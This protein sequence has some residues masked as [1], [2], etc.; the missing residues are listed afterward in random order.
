LADCGHADTWRQ[1]VPVRDFAAHLPWLERVYRGEAGV[2][3]AAPVKLLIPTS[4][5]VG[6]Q[7]L[8]P[9]TAPLGAAIERAVGAW[10]ANLAEHWPG[11]LRGPAYWAISPPLLTPSKANLAIPVALP[12]DLDYFSPTMAKALARWLLPAPEAPDR[13][14]FFQ[15][16]A[17]MLLAQ[18][19]LAMVS[20]WSPSFLMLLDEAIRQV[21][22]PPYLTWAERWPKLTLV[23]CWTHGEA[24]RWL[25]AL[26]PI[27]GPITLQGKGLMAT[28]GIT[29]I[30]METGDPVV[31]LSA[32]LIEFRGATGVCW[33]EETV[34]GDDYEI[35]LS[36]QAGLYRY[37]TGDRVRVTSWYAPGVPCLRFLGRGAAWSDLVG[38]KLASDFVSGVLAELA[39]VAWSCLLAGDRQ[40]TL[41]LGGAAD[42]ARCL[43]Q[44]EQGLRANPYYAQAVACGQL[45]PLALRTVPA[46]SLAP[47]LE[48]LAM[49]QGCRL[50]DVKLPSLVTD[51]DLLKHLAACS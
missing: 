47:L 48:H 42:P 38:E 19:E 2:L 7:K 13:E 40:Y 27:L 22:G 49:R 24:A 23:S 30:P 33:P 35:I 43:A 21:A 25:P 4:G 5:S 50:G 34:L 26:V 37:A 14:R 16:T 12:G 36:T 31:A 44:A 18:R 6:G 9:Y 28:E 15:Q 11:A 32:H 39:A 29:S 1:R 41:L 3:T 46:A 51:S 45:Q 20:V 8:I 10:L 17:A